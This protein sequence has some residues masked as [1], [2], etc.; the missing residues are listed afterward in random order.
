[1]PSVYNMSYA[2]MFGI[3]VPAE[4]YTTYIYIYIYI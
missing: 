2:F 3:H 1:M 4:K